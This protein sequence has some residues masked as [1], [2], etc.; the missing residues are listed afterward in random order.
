[1]EH[2][3]E[4]AYVFLLDPQGETLAHT[5]TDALPSELKIANI[6]GSEEP[7]SIKPLTIDQGQNFYDIGVPVLKGEAGTIHV[8]ISREQISAE[9]S[10]IT[11]IVLMVVTTVLLI[12]G[13]GGA[14]IFARRITNPLTTFIKSVQA[15]SSGDLE[16]K[17]IVNTKDEISTLADSFNVMLDSLRTTNSHLLNEKKY[18]DE[19]IN[20]LPGIFCLIDKKGNLKQWNRHLE[21]ITGYS[22]EEIERMTIFDYIEGEDK[23]IAVEMM[24]EAFSKGSVITEIEFYTKNREKITLY[25]TGYKISI[26]KETYFIGTGF[27]ITNQKRA[28]HLLLQTKQDWE[29]T[30]NSLSEMITIHDRDYNI[31]NANRAAQHLL[32][33]PELEN[34]LKVKCFEY[35]HGSN[36]PP[37]GCPSCDCLTTGYPCNFEIF[38]PY[39]N[40]HLEIRAMPRFDADNNI[41]GLIHVVR[42]IT[43]RKQI[44]ERIKKGKTEWEITFD[45]AS[46]IIVLV[47]K[48]LNIIRCNR[49]FSE[50]TQKPIQ[51][52]IGKKFTFFLST[53]PE[54]S[55]QG[56]LDG[57]TEIK[58][59]NGHWLQLSYY[60]IINDKGEFLHSV[61]IG[62]DITIIKNTQ[63]K[64]I[65]SET[66]MK[67]RV[68]ELEKFYNMAVGRELR[69][70]QLK[71][72]IKKLNT[73]L[74]QCK[75]NGD[76]RKQ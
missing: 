37:K 75:G 20:S 34:T 76:S 35:Y 38:E 17:I 14:M 58:L 5:F 64:L 21:E 11:K 6:V 41:T 28:E 74:A 25:L 3:K 62:T 50:F 27:D 19:V 16:Q 4:I 10:N 65:T 40:K 45:N 68:D 60:P 53:N 23:N 7:F 55:E 36:G 54:Q 42:D 52:L 48:D 63:E 1:M 47:D 51:D 32:K 57:Q 31:I 13:G 29:H 71:K 66:E 12:F 69:M 33:L 43:E 73:E 49:K 61:L 46:E 72:E 39:L 24:Q 2:F 44:E 8:G 18:S 56:T 15:V 9:V 59:D 26:D 67:K 70:R 30:F 22:H